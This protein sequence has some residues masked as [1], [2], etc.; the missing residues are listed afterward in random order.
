MSW[1]SKFVFDPIQA[2]IA[3]AQTSS[4]PTAA[5]VGGAAGTAYT[6]IATDV[7]TGL[8]QPLTQN[9]AAAV[10]NQAIKDLEDGI[11]EVVDVFLT[12]SL[13]TAGPIGAALAPEAVQGANILLTFGEQHGLTFL[14]SLF[15]HAKTQVNAG[16]N[17]P[18]S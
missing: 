1:L 7:T 11:Q 17:A 2:A 4:N 10:G 3:R 9:S 13:G 16:P 12:A 18:G 14:S 8:N 15:H 6:K 5:A